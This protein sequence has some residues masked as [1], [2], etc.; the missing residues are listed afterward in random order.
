ML[1]Q[2]FHHRQTFF[3]D[4]FFALLFFEFRRL[5]HAVTHPQRA[6]HQYDAKQERYAPAPA[7]ELLIGGELAD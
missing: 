3:D 7:Q 6:Q 4:R 5:F 1:K 2:R